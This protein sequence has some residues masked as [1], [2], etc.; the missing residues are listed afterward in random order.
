MRRTKWLALG[1][2][3]APFA[4]QAET[5]DD[6]GEAM[7]AASIIVTGTGLSL[8]PGT[9]A[10]GSVVIDRDRL[11]DAA[12]GRIESAGR[13]RGLPAVPPL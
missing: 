12:S 6:A 8:P 1:M 5:P 2:A 13:C 10:Y 4:A 7:A 11:T 9:P 3:M